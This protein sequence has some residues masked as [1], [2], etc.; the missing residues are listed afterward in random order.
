M[1]RSGFL[2]LVVACGVTTALLLALALPP[3]GAS[4][5]D[6]KGA[7][8][9]APTGPTYHNKGLGVRT[10]G[11]SGWTMIADKQGAVSSWKRLATWNDKA[12]GAQVVLYTRPRSAASLDALMGSVRTEWNKSGDRLRLDAMRKVDQSAMNPVGKVIVDGSFTRKGTPKKTKDG[13]PPPPAESTPMRVQATYYLGEGHEFLLYVTTRATHWTRLRKDLRRMRDEFAFDKV[14]EQGPTGEGSYRN[15][16]LGFACRFPKGHTVVQ[17]QRQHHVVKFVGLSG[18]DPAL[19]VYAFP[20]EED[21]NADARRLVAYYTEDKAGEA[22]T[23]RGEVSGTEGVEVKARA[24]IDGVDQAIFIA[25]VKRGDTCYRLR[26][27]V[28]AEEEG[29]GEA[30]FRAFVGSFRFGG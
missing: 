4:A 7:K 23:R 26:C 12:T 28:P 16:Q 1:P 11:P 8:K 10:S 17:P 3:R 21:A 5:E 14:V 18:N 6:E 30:A 13:V 2:P 29:K 9:E 19:S 27:V 20:Y 15:E 22:T 24:M 25:V